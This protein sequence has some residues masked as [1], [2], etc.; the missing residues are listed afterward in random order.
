[1]FATG[2]AI[3][4]TRAADGSPVGLTVNSFAS[5]SLDPPL[6]LW[7]LSRKSGSLPAFRQATHYAILVLAVEQKALAE[8]FAKSGV[9]RWQGLPITAGVG[10]VPLLPDCAATFECQSHAQHEAGDHIILVGE[11]QRVTL[12]QQA[13]PLLF[14]GSRFYT[15]HPLG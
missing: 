6:V 14:H 8:C 7:S 1:M 9:D 11:V 4:T 3:M 5:V 10:D 15:E 12:R 13:R 2:V